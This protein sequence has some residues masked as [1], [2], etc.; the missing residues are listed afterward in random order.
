MRVLI[1]TQSNYVRTIFINSLIPA[2]ITL[3]HTEHSDNV[4]NKI[5]QFYP[6][7]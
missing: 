5:Q 4:I 3:F 1:Y 6:K 7:F 2:G